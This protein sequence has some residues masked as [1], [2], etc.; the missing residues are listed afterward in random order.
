M[1]SETKK[2]L[3]FSIIIPTYNEQDYIA[4]CIESIL[5]QNYDKELIEIVIVDGNSSDNTLSIIRGYQQKH[6]CIKLKENPGRRTPQSLNIGIKESKGDAVI[7]LGA[8]TT[9]DKDFIFYN[10]KYLAEL[11]VKVTGGTQINKGLNFMQHIIGLAM[12]NPFAMAS[13]PYRWSKKE[14]FVDTVVYAAYK[15]EIFNEVGFFEENFTIS[16]DAEFNWRIRKAGYKIFFSPKIKSYYYPRKNLKKFI[17]QMFRY[18]IL[19]VNV[20]KKHLSAF[21]LSHI[22]PPFFVVILITLFVLMLISKISPVY[23]FIFIVGYFVV[24]VIGI[25]YKSYKE[26]TLYLLILPLIIFLMHFTWG[27]GFIVGLILPRSKKW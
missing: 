23:F 10:N 21:K 1:F 2:L 11:N 25:I 3:S 15:R 6:P 26:S 8:H 17:F 19:R 13:A 18:G 27:L 7:I 22:V 14:Q 9:L 16:E 4:N 5:N 20:L 24:N 12:E